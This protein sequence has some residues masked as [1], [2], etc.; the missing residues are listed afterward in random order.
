MNEKELTMYVKKLQECDQW[1]AAYDILFATNEEH[2]DEI[3][4]ADDII[5][6]LENR[7]KYFAHQLSP[8]PPC[9]LEN[10]HWADTYCDED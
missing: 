9:R 10:D 3:E 8:E 7:V 6:Q 2:I 4:W 1:K 5:K